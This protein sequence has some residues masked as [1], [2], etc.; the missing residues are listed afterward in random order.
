MKRQAIS[1]RLHLASTILLVAGL[2]TACVSPT[3]GQLA[4]AEAVHQFD[5]SRLPYGQR[6]TLVQADYTP[7]LYGLN[8]YFGR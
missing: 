7:R 2:A 6:V 5:E 8:P 4:E 3:P 1:K